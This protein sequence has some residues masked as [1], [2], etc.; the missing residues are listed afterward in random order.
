MAAS[1]ELAASSM[2]FA[3]SFGTNVSPAVCVS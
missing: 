3:R 2:Y 1:A